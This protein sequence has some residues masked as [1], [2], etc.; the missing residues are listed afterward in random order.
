[1]DIETSATENECEAT[2]TNK[3]RKMSSS[4]DDSYEGIIFII[5]NI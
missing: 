1:M 3:K 4:S 2:I 5:R